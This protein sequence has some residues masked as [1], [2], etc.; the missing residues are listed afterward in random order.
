MGRTSHQFTNQLAAAIVRTVERREAGFDYL[1]AEAVAYKGVWYDR[2][3]NQL[4]WQNMINDADKDYQL[5]LNR[6][7]EKRNEF[8]P[9]NVNTH[10]SFSGHI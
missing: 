2:S 8:D 3:G 7:R 6:M 1:N 4:C 5:M 9:K 10:D